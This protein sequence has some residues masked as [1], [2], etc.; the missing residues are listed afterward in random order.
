MEIGIVGPK[1]AGKT[2]IFK[3]L[4]SFQTESEVGYSL[5]RAVVKVPDPRLDALAKLFNPKKVTYATISYLDLPHP[6]GKDNTQYFQTFRNAAALAVVIPLFGLDG[7]PWKERLQRGIEQYRDFDLSLALSDLLQIEKKL[8]YER[9]VLKGKPSERQLKRLVELLERMR[10]HL[11]AERPLRELE[12]TPEEEKEIRGYAFFSIK[13]QIIILNIGEEELPVRGQ[14][15]ERWRKEFPEQEVLAVAGNIEA[16]LAELPPEE[17]A[18]F[19]EDYGLS[20]PLLPAFIRA[21]YS[22]LDLISF[23]TVGEKE[24][25]AWPIKR[26]TE[27][28]KAAGAIHSDM[29]RGF[30]R[31]EVIQW[32]RLVELGSLKAAKERGEL[33]LEGKDYIV[34][35]GDIFHVRFAV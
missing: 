20:E 25:R 2:T 31:A 26:G 34:Q 24:V 12:M 10:K 28:K 5:N 23:F 7:S 27:A 3:A 1:G 9:K 4:A 35:D 32:S 11:E 15:V 16:E 6:G 18:E 17:A 13:P 19:L 22:T 30:I 14:I 33:R 29:E 21:C 8:E